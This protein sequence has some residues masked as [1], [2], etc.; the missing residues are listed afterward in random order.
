MSLTVKEVK[1][2]TDSVLKLT[3]KPTSGDWLQVYLE[4]LGRTDNDRHSGRLVLVVS[5]DAYS[6]YWS[7]MSTPLIEFIQTASNGYLI[8]KLTGGELKEQIN[9]TGDEMRDEL[10]KTIFE[11]RRDESLSK[12]DARDLYDDV[13]NSDWERPTDEHE[14]LY[15]IY[16]CE[17]WECIPQVENPEYEHFSKVIDL[18]KQGLAQH[19][20]EQ[21]GAV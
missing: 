11:Q 5:G 17:W 21:G 10:I 8:T 13:Q 14:L 1:A 4:D 9:A 3:I 6:H 15:R 19:V 18:L 7:H 16:D 20:A 12:E 2:S